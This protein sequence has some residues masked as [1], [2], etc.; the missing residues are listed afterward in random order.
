M[1]IFV[2]NFSSKGHIMQKRIS[3]IL[4]F[5]GIASV[6]VMLMTFDVSFTVLWSN[7]RQAGFWLAASVMLWGVLYG[8][9]ALALR[10]IILNSGAC[11]IRFGKLWQ[12]VVSGFALNTTVPVGGV[13]G[14]PYRIMEL[15]KY[16]GLERATSSVVLFAMTHVFSHFWFWLT[17]I[18]FYLSLVLSGILPFPVIMRL[19]IVLAAILSIG[20]IW[21]FTRG[22][23]YGLVRK[24][25][26][27]VGKIPGLKGWCERF[28]D[29]NG[30]RLQN[31]DKQIAQLKGQNSRA[32]YESFFLGYF[33]R[34]LQSFEVFFILQIFGYGAGQAFM[35]YAHTF[36]LSFLIIAFTSLI[37]NLIGFIPMQMGGREGG[38]ALTVSSFGMTAGYGLSISLICRVREIIWATIGLLIMKL[39]K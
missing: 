14:E 17:G 19:C 3:T 30:D 25:V 8:L 36:A 38:F 12:I 35:G 6:I 20:G 23:R 29:R 31:I 27:L 11:P 1:F 24:T 15:S 7:I 22:Y 21:L 34:I 10:I 18:V 32:F 5:I 4:F 28:E 2:P 37:A 9:N 13:G 26:R 39:S 16:I 33:G